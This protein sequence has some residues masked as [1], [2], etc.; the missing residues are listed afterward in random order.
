[1]KNFIKLN[2]VKVVLL[3]VSVIFAFLFVTMNSSAQN[4]CAPGYVAS[5]WDC[6]PNNTGYGNYGYSSSC[7]YGVSSD[8]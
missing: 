2:Q 8:G 3:F 5:G 7:P 1:M 6:V 4:Y